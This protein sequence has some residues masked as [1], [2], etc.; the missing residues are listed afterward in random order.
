MQSENPM[1][2]FAIVATHVL[3][4]GRRDRWAASAIRNAVEARKEQ[5]CLQFDVVLPL[6]E[7]NLGILIE[8]YV[9]RQAWEQ[10]FEQPYCRDFMD[11][12]EPM[13]HQRIRTLGEVVDG[14]R[15]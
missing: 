15:T 10:H 12:V 8:R 2:V 4:P 13:L 3:K 11:A 5:G 1:P 7:P 6:E 9:D 14:E